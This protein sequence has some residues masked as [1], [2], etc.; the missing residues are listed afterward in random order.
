MII[1]VALSNGFWEKDDI[2]DANNTSATATHPH[3]LQNA[4]RFLAGDFCWVFCKVVKAQLDQAQAQTYAAR[5]NFH[6]LPLHT[7]ADVLHP[8]I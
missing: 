1:C 2:V 8:P 4:S 7:S 6:P 5:R 3:H